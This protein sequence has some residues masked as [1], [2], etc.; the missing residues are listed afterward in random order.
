ML[1]NTVPDFATIYSPETYYARGTRGRR[2]DVLSFYDVATL[3]PIDEVKI[4]PKRGSGATHRT[5]SGRSDDGRF[6]YVFNMTPGYEC[7]RSRCSA[8]SGHGRN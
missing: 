5:Y 3:S 2:T 6:V 7:Q 1:W 8:K 4:P